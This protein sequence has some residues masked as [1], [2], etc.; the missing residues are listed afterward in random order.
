M[1]EVLTALHEKYPRVEE[2]EKEKFGRH[3]SQILMTPRPYLLS[4]RIL[5]LFCALVCG[6]LAAFVFVPKLSG[7][8]WAEQQM[9]SRLLAFMILEL[10][11]IVIVQ[12]F[13]FS[14]PQYLAKQKLNEISEEKGEKSE[15]EF[16]R[17]FQHGFS[18]VFALARILS[19]LVWMVRGCTRLLLSFRGI[20]PDVGDEEITEDD[21]LQMVD[22]GE[23]TGAIE[24][25]EKEMI[26]NIFEFNNQTAEDVMTHRTNVSFIW[27]HDDH[28][29]VMKIIM[30]TGLSRF[31]VYDEDMDDIIGILS[32][33]D[34]LLNAHKEKPKDMSS[35][36]R[37][38]YFVPEHVQADV[39]FRDMQKRKTHMAIVVD[40]YGGVSG[41]VTMEDLLELIVGNIYDEFDPQA[42]NELVQLS[43]NLWR[44]SGSM[45]LDEISEA[46]GVELPVDE[47]YDTLG[48]LI[49]NQM[50]VIPK[51]GS[52]P[53]MDVCGLHI[54][55]EKLKNH[56][57]ESALVSKLEKETTADAADDA[58][59]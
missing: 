36:I 18:V 41:L 3:L 59:D 14:F 5:R 42:E 49:F 37:E 22:I 45:L 28:D 24:E 15:K 27:I 55:V 31:P 7:L 53:E 13:G 26:E 8:F 38:A 2:Q 33:R 39:L 29:T 46:L 50:T 11:L 16:L 52:R 21:I 34:Y 48:G 56:H 43:D 35:L 25:N 58:E 51:D 23:E 19:P 10:I 57:V 32:T 4:V 30:S 40:E 54:Q 44:I 9:V 1:D 17:G 6:G 47:D 12:V 20:S